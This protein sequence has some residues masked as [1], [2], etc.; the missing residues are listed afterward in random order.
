MPLR[1]AMKTAFFPSKTLTGLPSDNMEALAAL[2]AEFERFDGHARELP[3]HHNDYVEALSILRAFA[4]ARTAKLA[5]FPEIGAQQRQNIASIKAYF[6]QL[7][8][9][10]RSELYSR[11]AKGHFEAKTEEYLSLFARVPGYEFTQASFKRVQELV[12]ELRELF[13]NS[14]LIAD[15]EKRRL[16]RKLE[17]MRG[18]LHM[19]T[20]DIDRFW[21]FLGEAAIAMRK[22]G[23]DL[24]PISERVLELGRII[25]SVLFQKEGIKALPELSRLLARVEPA[26][27]Q[28]NLEEII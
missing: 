7:R 24:N 20:N 13:Q 21:G 22:F 16:L 28:P 15:E 8:D 4:A 9:T 23:Q 3:D 2:C 6:A 18:E 11:Q 10:V 26:P 25:I 27:I 1:N 14:S 17:A 12:I 5:P 19:K